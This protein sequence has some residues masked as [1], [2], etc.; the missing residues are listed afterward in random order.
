MILKR[1]SAI[2]VSLA[3]VMSAVNVGSLSVTSTAAGT[4]AVF[5]VAP[6]GSDSGN[7]TIEAPFATLEKARD[8]VR[9][10]NGDMTG[11]IVVYLRGGD[12]RLTQPVEFDTRD[13]GTGG[14]TVRYEAYD[15]EAPVING[16]QQVTGWTKYNDKLWSAPLDRDIKL[17]NLY[18]NDKR[19]NMGSVQVQAKGEEVL[20]DKTVHSGVHGCLKTNFIVYS[21]AV[22]EVSADT[23]NQYTTNMETLTLL[24]WS[25]DN[26]TKAGIIVISIQKKQ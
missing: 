13:S 10:I 16:A 19:A 2:A 17:R 8:E 3:A 15:K 22:T 24:L 25:A 23:S 20:F 12:Y 5:F 7:G 26:I 14:F 18:V 11:D 21:I 1:M 6:D 9:K 4:Q